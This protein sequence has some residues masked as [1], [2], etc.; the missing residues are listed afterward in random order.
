MTQLDDIFSPFLR[1]IKRP[2][3]HVPALGPHVPSFSNLQ[4]RDKIILKELI[5]TTYYYLLT[6]LWVVLLKQDL[7]ST[8]IKRLH[9]GGASG[10]V[11]FSGA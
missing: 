6:M 8:T 10:Q 4:Y 3:K 5:I 7:C 9:L 11:L 2:Y 1:Y